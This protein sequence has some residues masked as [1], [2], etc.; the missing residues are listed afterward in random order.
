[1]KNEWALVTGASSGIGR[2]LAMLFSANGYNLV[3]I[4]R[5][6]ER[7]A[8]VADE[9]V[10]RHGVQAK[11]LVKDLA[12][13]AA[14]SEILAE[15]RAQEIT[16]QV[17]VNN[18]GSGLKGAFAQTALQAHLDIIHVNVN[19]LVQLTRLFL[20]PMVAAGTG[21]ILNIA[22]TAAFQPGP[23]MAVYYAT[24]AFVSSFSCALADELAD[25]GV[26]VTAL[27]PGPTRTDFHRRAGTNRSERLVARWM[28]D[29]DEVAR[30][31]YRALMQGQRMVIPGLANKA[32]F[33]LA[34][35][36]PT[37]VMARL[38]GKIIA[39]GK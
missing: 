9:L 18:A 19:A 3:L 17:L 6:R 37:A 4:A 23:L 28:M 14:P 39:G 12:A 5:N 11:M 31:G 20:P 27:F 13:P 16:I 21:R 34:R 2:E 15:I 33:I 8:K 25:S 1:M 7:L 10:N 32:G 30:I 24:K 26:T 36:L 38:A 29:A 35:L 22:S